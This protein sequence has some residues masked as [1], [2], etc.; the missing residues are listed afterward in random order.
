VYV[1]QQAASVMSRERTYFASA[2]GS[3]S[4]LWLF[5]GGRAGIDEPRSFVAVAVP[6]RNHRPGCR[7]EFDQHAGMGLGTFLDPPASS[8]GILEL[9]GGPRSTADG[10]VKNLSA[11]GVSVTSDPWN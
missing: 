1:Y 4:S 8:M 11:T 3:A 2:C 5:A 7:I 10:W 6:D 9:N